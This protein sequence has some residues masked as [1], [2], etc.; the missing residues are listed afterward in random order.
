MR[1]WVLRCGSRCTWPGVHP[2]LAGVTVALLIPVFTPER[3]RVERA[4][5]ADPGVPPVAELAV[6]PRGQPLAAGV[7]LDQ[8]TAAGPT[9]GPYVSFVVLPLFA[10]VNAGVRLD[11][12]TVTPRCGHR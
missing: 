8:R 7:D 10:L 11:A 12:D 5:E 9:S 3:R 2:T 1:C 4:V 6:R